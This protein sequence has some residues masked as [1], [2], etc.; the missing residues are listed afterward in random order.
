MLRTEAE[1]ARRAEFY[2]CLARTFLPPVSE[3]G[4]RGFTQYTADELTELGAALG[5]PIAGALDGLCHALAATPDTDALLH[6]YRRLFLVLPTPAHLNAGWY[7]DSTYRGTG[8]ARIEAVYRRYGLTRSPDFHD[9][10]DHL[11]VELEF[12][13]FMFGSAVRSG[14]EAET[15]ADEAAGFLHRYVRPWLPVLRA[16]IASAVSEYALP[17]VYL[18]LALIAETAVDCDAS[19]GTPPVRAPD[20]AVQGR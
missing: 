16:D 2:L 15:F 17:A 8:V 19:P 11:A 4:Y 5:Y 14:S 7:L 18:Y 10:P 20:T 12:A 3:H 13:A 1:L 6:A 9:V